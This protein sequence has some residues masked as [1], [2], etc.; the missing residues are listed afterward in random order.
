MSD[1]LTTDDDFNFRTPTNNASIELKKKVVTKKPLKLI[2]E[3]RCELEG[4]YECPWCGG[5][6]M[7]DATY[8]EQ[9]STV[10]E[11]LYCGNTVCVEEIE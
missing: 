9:V 11:C 8:L 3:D 2:R 6:I 10:F 5:H 1:C 4:P 7:L